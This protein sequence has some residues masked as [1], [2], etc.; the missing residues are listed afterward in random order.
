MF[1]G[2]L[3]PHCL[4][5][6]YMLFSGF[7]IIYVLLA[8]A[9][10][11]LPLTFFLSLPSLPF[12]LSSSTSS[13]LPFLSLALD[14][15]LLPIPL[16]YSTNISGITMSNPIFPWYCT[17]QSHSSFNSIP[18]RYYIFQSHLCCSIDL[19]Q[20]KE[21]HRSL[22]LAAGMFLSIRDNLL[23]KLPAS[24]EK[25]VDTDPRV[26]EAY[27]QMSQAEAQEVT[28]ARA[29]ELGHK[30]AVVTSLAIETSAIFTQ[31]S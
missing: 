1:V 25:G 16:P 3:K 11:L 5:N 31:S 12:S 2:S 30:P 28:L 23:P 17:F 29:L 14:I 20:A 19:D 4:E 9:H 24:P 7:E 22:K 21:V 15:L 13:L 10:P 26:V 27:A 6:Y 8:I 18:L